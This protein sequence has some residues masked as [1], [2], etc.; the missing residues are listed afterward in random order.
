MWIVAA[1]HKKNNGPIDFYESLND[2]HLCSHFNRRTVKQRLARIGLVQSIMPDGSPDPASH[3]TCGDKLPVLQEARDVVNT[4]P[5]KAHTGAVCPVCRKRIVPAALKKF[6][7]PYLLPVNPSSKARPLPKPRR[8]EG[9]QR[10]PVSSRSTSTN[11][12]TRDAA[13]E[14]RNPFVSTSPGCELTFLFHGLEATLRDRVPASVPTVRV[15][16]QHCGGSSLTVYDGKVPRGGTFNLVSRRHCGFPF[17]VVM[18]VNGIRDV[19]LSSCCEYRYGVGSRLGGPQGRFSLVGLKGGSPC[20]KCVLERRLHDLPRN[21]P[22]SL[23]PAGK[24]ACS[25]GSSSQ[26]A[27]KIEPTVE[28]RTSL[29]RRYSRSLESL[30]T[31]SSDVTENDVAE[32]NLDTPSPI[33]ME[34]TEDPPPAV[35][36]P[37]HAKNCTSPITMKAANETKAPHIPVADNR[38]KTSNS[39][40]VTNQAQSLSRVSD[41]KSVHGTAASSNKSSHHKERAKLDQESTESLAVSI[42]PQIVQ[43]DPSEVAVSR[44]SSRK[45]RDSSQSSVYFI[46]DKKKQWGSEAGHGGS[47]SSD[48]DAQQGATTTVV[49]VDVHVC[50]HPSGS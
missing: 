45:V 49:E 30:G 23:P 19:Q 38:A 41:T 42:S 48:D 17:S 8:L 25:T 35:E 7:S 13:S 47:F 11:S 22:K 1:A 29:E 15:T 44:D 32:V 40:R 33:T 9:P 27:H 31:S 39:S 6:V 21:A 24:Q 18:F 12:S 14:I 4:R 36:E 5:E 37:S 16:Q 46:Q 20:Y 10:T 50:S 26:Q 3:C 28:D 43:S 2:V 34:T